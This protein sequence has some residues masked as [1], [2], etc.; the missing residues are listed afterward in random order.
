VEDK[1]A[2]ASWKARMRFVHR[3]A[4]YPAAVNIFDHTPSEAQAT[5]RLQKLRKD[6]QA[7]EDRH[8]AKDS[9]IL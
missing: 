1:Q 6:I 8:L 2:I 4:Y 7:L 9:P 5:L 3:S